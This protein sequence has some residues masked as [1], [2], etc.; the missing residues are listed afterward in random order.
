M[1]RG[2]STLSLDDK[3]RFAI[4]TKYRN[5]LL[6]DNGGEIICTINIGDP[7]LLLY[8]LSEWQIVEQ[9]LAALSNMKE[10]AKRMQRLVLGNAMD[11]QLDKNGRVLLAPNLRDYAKLGKKIVLVGQSNKFE[12][13]DE[14]LWQERMA[15]DIAIELEQDFDQ[16]EDLG[17]FSF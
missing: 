15:K 11:Y 13:W 6:A 16:D 3:G 17:D 1:F 2:T 5:Q 14:T 9:R 12:I 10:R 7:C 8:S 4:P